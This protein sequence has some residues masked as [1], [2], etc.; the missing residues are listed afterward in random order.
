MDAGVPEPDRPAP[1]EERVISGVFEGK[2]STRRSPAGGEPE[3]FLKASPACLRIDFPGC[4]S[5]LFC[6]R[7]GKTQRGE[8]PP[9]HSSRF[10]S[11]RKPLR[12]TTSTAVSGPSRGQNFML[13]KTAKIACHWSPT[14]STRNIPIKSGT[15]REHTRG[16]TGGGKAVASPGAGTAETLDAAAPNFIARTPDDR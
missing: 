4:G 9:D 14:T 7:S 13:S 12:A 10:R 3:A 1:R 16:K 11:I 2:L 6:A 8:C 15:Q 5:S